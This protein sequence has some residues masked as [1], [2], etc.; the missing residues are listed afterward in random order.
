[1]IDDVVEGEVVE[2]ITISLGDGRNISFHRGEIEFKIINGNYYFYLSDLVT[3]LTKY[4]EKIKN[5]VESCTELHKL[6]GGKEID[7]LDEYFVLS[8]IIGNSPMDD[9]TSFIIHPHNEGGEE[10]CGNAHHIRILVNRGAYQM[11]NLED[12]IRHI[13]SIELDPYYELNRECKITKR[14]R[15]PDPMRD[16]KLPIAYERER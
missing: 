2:E 13:K 12:V 14:L 3:V 6:P 7:F 15:K 8:E 5:F 10:D 4:D 11:Y 16:R 1:M 9:H